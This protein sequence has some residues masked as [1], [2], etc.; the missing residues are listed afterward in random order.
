MRIGQNF[1]EV[2]GISPAASVQE[3]REA[4]RQ[5]AFRYHPDR[6]QMDLATNKNMEKINEA[7]ATLSDPIK[8]KEYDIPMGYRILVPKFKEGSKVIVSSHSSTPFKDHVGWIESEPVKDMFRFWYKVKFKSNNLDS[9]S[10][11]AEEELDE[12]KE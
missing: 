7:Y 12:M 8:R 9:V 5:Q 10:R 6:N 2:L 1:Y 3:I 11:F 4:Y